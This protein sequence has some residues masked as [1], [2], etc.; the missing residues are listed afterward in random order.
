MV[1]FSRLVI[2]VAHLSIGKTW[3]RYNSFSRRLVNSM[4]NNIRL[5]YVTHFLEDA[6]YRP[7]VKDMLHI[8]IALAFAPS[9]SN[10]SLHIQRLDTQ[11][12]SL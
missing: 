12:N 3:P 11:E 2:V 6:V 7:R 5:F 4:R 10:R 9:H 1:N 8:M